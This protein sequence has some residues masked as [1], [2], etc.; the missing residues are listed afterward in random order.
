M[1]S[2]IDLDAA[3]ADFFQH[4]SGRSIRVWFV[5]RRKSILFGICGGEQLWRH[6]GF[7]VLRSSIYIPKF[8]SPLVIPD[9]SRMR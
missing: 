2:V 4:G 3:T 1:P 8:V 5:N 9:K 6:N 7:L